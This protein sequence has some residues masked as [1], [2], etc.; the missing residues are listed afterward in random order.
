MADDTTTKI[1]M[2]KVLPHS[3][4]KG[5]RSERDLGCYMRGSI[6]VGR[7]T[8]DSEVFSVLDFNQVRHTLSVDVFF[9]AFQLT[10]LKDRAWT[11]L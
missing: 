2:T 7:T 8:L 1:S 9:M 6:G 10:N 4:L 3:R 11:T 5:E